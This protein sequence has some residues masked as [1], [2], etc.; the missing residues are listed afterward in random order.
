[1]N[2]LIVTNMYPTEKQKFY[3]IFVYEQV[4]ALRSL[5]QK[6]LH[7]DVYFVRG[8]RSPLNYF[9]DIFRIP[10]LVKKKKYNLV[11]VHYGLTLI[12]VLL[13]DCPVVVTWHGSDLLRTPVKYICKLLKFKAS[14][15]IVVSRNLLNALGGDAEIIPCGIDV[16]KFLYPEKNVFKNEKIEIK[17][18]NLRVLF[19]SDPD[20]KVK[21]YPLF[22]KTCDELE[23][24]GYKIEEI[25]LRNIPR[26][27]V[28]SVFWGSDVMI[29]TS[30]SEGS[31]T[32]IKE[33]IAAKLPFVSVDVGDVREWCQYVSFGVV[34]TTRDPV[35]IAK[36]VVSLLS[37]IKDRSK[38]ENSAALEKMDLVNIAEKI[39]AIYDEMS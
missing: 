4:K 5:F 12:S 26:E 18:N 20:N 7:I 31:P 25:F 21:N 14:R 11:H 6:S 23:K 28:P 19:P 38:L 24:H 30:F 17:K 36:K 2:I 39:K 27:D 35:L 13:V 15:S 33:A 8:Y 29:L 1:M 16:A 3:G 9:I 10:L 34:E 37:N 22:R 32:V